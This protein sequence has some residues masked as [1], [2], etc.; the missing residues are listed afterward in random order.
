M[1]TMCKHLF[2]QYDGVGIPQAPLL[3]AQNFLR[4]LRPL[5]RL[6]RALNCHHKNILRQYRP[7]NLRGRRSLTPNRHRKKQREI[8]SVK[9]CRLLRDC[10][11]LLFRCCCV[12][13]W[14]DDVTAKTA[15]AICAGTQVCCSS[16]GG[17]IFYVFAALFLWNNVVK[18]EKITLIR[19]V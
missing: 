3:H 10:F 9:T 7:I 14:V 16:N 17:L 15:V 13:K 4:T 6:Q 11:S 8:L 2:H 5:L 12:V 18:F 19:I 1:H